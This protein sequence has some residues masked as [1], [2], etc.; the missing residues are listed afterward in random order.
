MD[1]SIVEVKS[2]LTRSGGYL[3]PVVSHSLQPYRGC[4][5]GHSLCGSG[6]YVQHMAYVTRGRRWGDF[7]E[8]RVNAA[9]CYRAEY[10][11]ERAWA[12]RARDCFGI[13]LSSATE[14]F[15]PAERKHG[16]TR[17]VLEAMEELPPDRLMLQTHSA[18]VAHH[19]DMLLRLGAR[20][21]LRI[22]L[23]IETDRE[24]I[25]GLPPPAVPVAKRL[26]AAR[27]LHEAG[28]YVV[29]T[30][31]PLLPIED[32]EGFFRR[33]SQ[34]ASAVV[35]DHFIR[36]DGSREGSRTRKTPMPA[37]MAALDPSSVTLEYRDRM[38]EVASRYLPGRVGVQEDGFGGRYL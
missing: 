35:I 11:R 26:E 12:R 4:A 2:I 34:S 32:P 3:R 1:V 8:V 6:C 30:V 22:H 25:P 18:D 24:R 20:M 17:S 21:D 16:V 27:Q 13:F 31:S 29:V 33:I 28:L 5:F 38:V 15:M 7:L 9:D 10:A 37:A 19:Q 36:G 23:S 14:P